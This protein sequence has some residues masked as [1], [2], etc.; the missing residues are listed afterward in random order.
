MRGLKS[1]RLKTA[2]P[3]HEVPD[4]F[5]VHFCHFP[6]NKLQGGKYQKTKVQTGVCL[7]I[8]TETNYGDPP[9]VLSGTGLNDLELQ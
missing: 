2:T 4:A 6:S 1:L 3:G 5:V 8:L 9:G 7:K